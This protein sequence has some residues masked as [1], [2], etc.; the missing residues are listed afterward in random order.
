VVIVGGALW[1][2]PGM[3]LS[4]PLT[5]ILKLIFDHIE[6]MKPWGFLLG[7]IV[8]TAPGFMI[9]KKNIQVVFA[10]LKKRKISSLFQKANQIN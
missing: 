3:F 8:P 5:A 6:S 7:N 2:I 10:H 1:G 9:K 4:I